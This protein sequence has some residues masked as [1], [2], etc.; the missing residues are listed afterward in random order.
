MFHRSVI[1]SLSTFFASKSSAFAL[2]FAAFDASRLKSVGCQLTEEVISSLATFFASHSAMSGWRK[3][4]RAEMR[5]AGIVDGN[6]GLQLVRL[7]SSRIGVQDPFTDQLG[8]H[9]EKVALS[10]FIVT[11]FFV[12]PRCGF[13]LCKQLLQC[14]VLK[15]SK[16]PCSNCACW[17]EKLGHHFGVKIFRVAADGL[18]RWTQRSCFRKVNVRISTNNIY[19]QFIV[20]PVC[21]ADCNAARFVC[22]RGLIMCFCH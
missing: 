4:Q 9:A 21:H 5:R 3:R 10:V 18:S 13:L 17:L 7:L 6:I 12:F 2:K 20:C 16:P 1:Y 8:S 22:H 19:E 11:V 15:Q 14:I